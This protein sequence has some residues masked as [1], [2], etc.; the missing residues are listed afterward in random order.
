MNYA[1]A[2]KQ[3]V[4]GSSRFIIE[5]PE[6]KQL[7]NFAYFMWAEPFAMVVPRPGEQPRLFAFVQPFQPMVYFIF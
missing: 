5:N 1:Y 3:K 6:R 4:D 2:L 7:A